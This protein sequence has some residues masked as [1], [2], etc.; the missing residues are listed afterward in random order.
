MTPARIQALE[1]IEGFVWEVHAMPKRMSWEEAFEQLKN[2][3]Y[4]KHRHAN[5]PSNWKATPALGEIT[6]IAPRPSFVV[7]AGA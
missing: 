7:S 1:E 6:H 2:E 4:P 5:V 3:F